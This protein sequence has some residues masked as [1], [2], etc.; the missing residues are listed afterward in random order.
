MPYRRSVFRVEFERRVAELREQSRKANSLPKELGDQNLAEVRDMVFQ[1]AIF[2]TSAALETY[3]KLII[4]SWVQALRRHSKGEHLPAEVR[5]SFARRRL[6]PYF[7]RFA[8]SEEETSL[9]Q[10]INAEADLWTFLKGGQNLPDFFD[11]RG[12]H[13]ACAYPS[14]KNM[15][16]LFARLGIPDFDARLGRTMRRDVEALIVAFQD[17]RTALAHAAPPRITLKDVKERLD[18]Q[19]RLVSA[20]DRILFNHI[21]R[22]GGPECWNSGP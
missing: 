3:L 14:H 19:V 15:R 17:I 10:A 18:D 5:A 6:T 20:I 8:Y 2:Q 7:K 9:H 16:R 11:G 12:L 1:C 21:T 4:E 22:H 13:E